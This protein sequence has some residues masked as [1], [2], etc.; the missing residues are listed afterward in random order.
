MA[1][2]LLLALQRLPAFRVM[3]LMSLPAT[4]VGTR[5][6]V[7]ESVNGANIDWGTALSNNYLVSTDYGTLTVTAQSITPGEDP[8]NPDPS[9]VDV[10]VNYPARRPVQR[11]GPDLG[12]D[13][14]E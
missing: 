8:D 7:G 6:E 9:Y 11:P 5:T 4:A 12:P 1:L 14:D 10:Q 13:R 3:M 2:R